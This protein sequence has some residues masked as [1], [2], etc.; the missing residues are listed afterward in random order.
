MNVPLDA[1]TPGTAWLDA[2]RT[3]VPA[4][5]AAFAPDVVVSQHG[6]D[7]HIWDPLAHLRVTVDAMGAAAR[8]VDAIA[9]RHASGRWLATGGGGYEAYRVVPRS[10]ALVWLA[11]AHREPPD[12]VPEAWRARW[13]DEAARYRGTPLPSTFSDDPGPPDDRDRTA[14]DAA[15]RIAL[16]ARAAVV[17]AL[18][19]EAVDR[20]WW[21]PAGLAATSGRPDEVDRGAPGHRPAG[22][23]GPATPGSG[24]GLVDL[25][26]A[27]LDRLDLAPRTIAPADPADARAVLAA[28]LGAG[29]MA[30]AAVSG[31]LIVGIALS[32]PGRPGGSAVLDGIDGLVPASAGGSHR[33]VTLGVAPEAR[34]DGLGGR[35]VRAL[36]ARADADR[37]ALWAAI[38]PGERDVVEPLPAR[39]PRRDRR[40]A[41][42]RGGLP[43]GLGPRRARPPDGR[44]RA[45]TLLSRRCR[46]AVPN[47]SRP[48]PTPGHGVV[49]LRICAY[50]AGVGSVRTGRAGPHRALCR[51]G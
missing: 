19:A 43:A 34:G 16:R 26:V 3:I 44:R 28:A 51:G 42:R 9:H 12:A 33:V 6:A 1:G 37:I 38:G 39:D 4:A 40:A 11:G 25:D 7:S 31:A 29:G 30:V 35:L 46:P 17:P 21:S 5:A 49:G 20:G 23:H 41:A 47:P 18:V 27:L 48:R 10:W 32:I 15:R 45:T 8:T 22:A 36:A 13:A 2:V 50:D 24:D 14:A